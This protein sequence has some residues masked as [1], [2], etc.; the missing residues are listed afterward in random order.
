MKSTSSS[1]S[2]RNT[3]TKTCAICGRSIEYRKKWT[4]Y[5]DEIKYCSEKCRRNKNGENFESQILELLKSR[6][7]GKT[8]CPSE[9][10][11]GTEKTNKELMEKVRMSARL[12]VAKGEIVITQNGKVVD[13]STAKGPIRLRKVP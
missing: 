7:S 6:G 9:V 11:Q 10:L 12:L 2:K 8:I 4:A 1:K 5:W 13:P 3:E